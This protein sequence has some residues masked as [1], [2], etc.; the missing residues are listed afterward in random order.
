VELHPVA[1]VAKRADQLQN[2]VEA[3]HAMF[4]FVN[5]GNGNPAYA[6]AAGDASW[7]VAAVFACNGL[8]GWLQQVSSSR[9]SS[10]VG[11]ATP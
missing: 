4:P 8:T 2:L 9:V 3:I 1:L 11:W 7:R 10:D 5:P 6:S